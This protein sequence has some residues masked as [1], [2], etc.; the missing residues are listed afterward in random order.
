MIAR[1]V[2]TPD[3]ITLTAQATID[4]AADLLRE[5]GIRHVP[6][7]DQHGALIGMLSDRDL[8]HLDLGRL[9]ADPDEAARH[10]ATPIAKVMS[11]D[12]ISVDP[13]ADLGDVI[14]IMLESRVGAV[15]VIERGSR[16]VVG[17]VSYV[18]VLRAVQDR[19]EEG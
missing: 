18:D 4:E 5:R 16:R 7:V 12:A 13:E 9:V 1:D 6:V 3:P 14:D 17:I 2:M 11:P 8:G 15:P 19:L 10:L